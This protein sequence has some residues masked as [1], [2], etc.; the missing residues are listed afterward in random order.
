VQNVER[1][2]VGGELD[3][4]NTGGLE[5]LKV[6]YR[7]SAEESA[8]L[9]QY[10]RSSAQRLSTKGRVLI[11]DD[12]LLMLQSLDALLTDS[13]FH[14]VAVES[15]DQALELLKTMAVDL[16]LSDIKFADGQ[17]DG[18]QFFISVQSQPHLRKVPFIFMSSLRDGVVIRSG[19]QLGADDYITKPIDPDYL[20]AAVEGKLKR[21]R[22]L[23]N[24]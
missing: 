16:I 15:V 9:E 11:V 23:E 3:M 10:L 14:T 4:N 19:I 8:K 21:Y 2:I 24:K 6:R 12:D 18:F 13:G 1:L 7:V 20:V 5:K 22:A 17:P